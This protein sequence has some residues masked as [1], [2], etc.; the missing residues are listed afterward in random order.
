[1]Y[2]RAFAVAVLAIFLDA[3]CQTKYQRLY[4]VGEIN[5]FTTFKVYHLPEQVLARCAL[6]HTLRIRMR[7][8]SRMSRVWS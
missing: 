3:L 8:D 1:M 4:L 5:S 6:L 7:L 2:T